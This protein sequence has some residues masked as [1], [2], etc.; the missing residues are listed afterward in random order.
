M[1][2]PSASTVTISLPSCPDS[3][4]TMRTSLKTVEQRDLVKKYKDL[5]TDQSQAVDM[6][7]DSLVM[8]ISSWNFTNAN[9]TPIPVSKEFIENLHSEDFAF[10]MSQLNIDT[11]KG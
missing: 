6:G 4:I 9:N 5:Q 11:K 1:Q 3:Q 10:L 8:L 7:I 2:Y